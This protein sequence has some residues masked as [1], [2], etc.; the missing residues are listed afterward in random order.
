MRCSYLLAVVGG[1]RQAE[2]RSVQICNREVRVAEIVLFHHAQG[3]TT[4]VLALADSWRAAGHTVHTP[5]LY[6]GATYAT[7]DEGM[8]HVRR[9]GFDTVQ[10]TGA[11]AVADLPGELVYA[12]MSLGVMAALPLAVNRPGA[13]G[14][15]VVSGFVPPSEFGTW[16]AGLP[17]QVHGAAG[18]PEF[19]DSGDLAAAEEFAAAEPAVEVFVYPGDSHLFADSSLPDFDPAAA[20]TFGDRALEFL[21]RVG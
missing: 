13:R 16:P 18:D 4:G 12:G 5:D 8:A 3:L 21:A 6:D 1:S 19:A 9:I 17:A 20:A 2:A 11:D 14:A 7:L 15:L 10:R